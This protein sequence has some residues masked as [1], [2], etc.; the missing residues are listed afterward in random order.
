MKLSILAAVLAATVAG[1]LTT[2]FGPGA[3][4]AQTNVCQANPS[5]VDPADPSIIVTSPSAGA[6]VT[7]PI[8]VEGKARVFEATVSIKLIDANGVLAN[9]TTRAAQGQVLSEF[10]ADISLDLPAATGPVNVCLLVFEVSAQDGSQTNVVQIPLTIAPAGLPST[11]T[12]GASEGGH[13][14]WLVAGL[15]LAGFGLVGGGLAGR[16][17]R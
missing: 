10:S 14:A 12:G 17:V 6:S 4:L 15:A 8:H 1:L 5:P 7:S 9:T 2:A 16:R 11:G 13:V 3:A